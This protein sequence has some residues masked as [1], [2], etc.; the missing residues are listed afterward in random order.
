MRTVAGTGQAGGRNRVV[1]LAVAAGMRFGLSWNTGFFGLDPD[2]LVGVARRAEELGFES[3]Y[4]PEHI[5]LY[6]DVELGGLPLPADAAIADPLE[7]LSFVAAA[8]DRL[9]LGTAVLL[10]P[11]HDPVVLAKRLATIDVLSRGRLRLLTIGVGALPGEA[12]A[13][14]VDYTSRGRRADEAIEVLRALWS[15]DPDGVSHHGE[16]FDFDRIC[17]FPKPYGSA[18]LPIHV[19]GSSAAAARR[20]G[21]SGAGYFPGGRLTPQQ[22]AEHWQVARTAAA[23]A[24][25][26]PDRL[27]LTRWGSLDL[28]R[29]DVAA[30]AAEGVTRLVINLGSTD[31]GGQLEELT[32]F[33]RRHAEHLTSTSLEVSE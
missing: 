7:C 18:H 13:V 19:G 1:K 33:A 15:G 25:H 8:T 9:R 23:A 31:L 6:P 10:L 5:A 3:I 28:S 24:G 2:Q 30:R 14:G 12:A 4:F 17:S 21:R 29:D 11:Y 20:A 32:E 26:D 16:F 22:R 27:E